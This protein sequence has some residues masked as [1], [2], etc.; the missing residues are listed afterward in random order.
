[1]PIRSADLVIAFLHLLD[2]PESVREQMP[3]ATSDEMLRLEQD[4]LIGGR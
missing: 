4:V 3:A 2:P 1:M